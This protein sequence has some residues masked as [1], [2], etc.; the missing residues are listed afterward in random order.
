MGNKNNK[1]ILVNKAN[2]KADQIMQEKKILESNIL[3]EEINK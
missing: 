3:K 1:E 2:E